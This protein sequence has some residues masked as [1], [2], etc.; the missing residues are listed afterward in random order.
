MCQGRPA[1]STKV[2]FGMRCIGWGEDS[3]DCAVRLVGI[4]GVGG[5]SDVGEGYAKGKGACYIVG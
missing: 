4:E 2:A 3:T 1:E 5:A